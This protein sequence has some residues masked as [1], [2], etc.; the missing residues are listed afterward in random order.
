MKAHNFM[1]HIEAQAREVGAH[2][3]LIAGSGHHR[4]ECTFAQVVAAAASGASRLQG[5]GLHAGDP[6]LL[7]TPMGVDFCTATLS[8]LHAGIVPVF[9]GEDPGRHRLEACLF[10]LPTKGLLGPARVAIL[11][12]LWRCLRA[13]PVYARLPLRAAPTQAPSL[14]V[15]ADHPACITFQDL[16]HG[17]P[18]PRTRTHGFLESLLPAFASA[19]ALEPGERDLPLIPGLVL[20]NLA[21]G[22]CS[23][24]SDPSEG[25]ASLA[26]RMLREQA[27]RVTGKA[28]QLDRL[29]RHALARGRPL[30]GLRKLVALGAPLYPSTA[31]RL[32]RAA[33]HASILAVY[34]GTETGP[35]A[36]LDTANLSAEDRS[37]MLH[38]A[39]LLVGIPCEA[40]R[41]RI[42][43]FADGSLPPLD[44]PSF[45]ALESPVGL[46]GEIVVAAPP[47][48]TPT[49][50]IPFPEE[51]R[52]V[53]Q[54]Q[55]WFR[56]GEAGTLDARGRLWRLGPAD[57]R[58]P[59]GGKENLFPFAIECAAT[60]IPG[61]RTA[62]AP[63]QGLH[64][65][66][67]VELEPKAD[68]DEVERQI[69]ARMPWARLDKI[70]LRASLPDAGN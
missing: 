24:L 6:V 59:L 68:R 25:M 64:P 67:T 55:L 9:P 66:L 63:A 22:V 32:R 28:N 49:S 29:A 53:V 48:F 41:V 43:H 5:L 42:L 47:S 14:A 7:L 52:L 10:A 51:S 37:A 35:I 31:D 46:P 38:G 18:H 21:S 12:W 27:N 33:P 39:G 8:A 44:A 54:G 62:S 19:L 20:A 2:A 57:Q 65:V 11:R 34:G 17:P 58:L 61:V 13:I 26:E 30:S 69:R 23:I 50:R 36:T 70:V 45:A 60:E 3:A 56:T 15:K 1:A 16:P 40:G 4:R